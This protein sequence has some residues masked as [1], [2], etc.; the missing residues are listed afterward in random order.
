MQVLA[1]D[2]TARRGNPN[3]APIRRRCTAGPEFTTRGAGELA[4]LERNADFLRVHL[5]GAELADRRAAGTR[6]AGLAATS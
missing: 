4:H 6:R 3:C 5:G 2:G 1:L